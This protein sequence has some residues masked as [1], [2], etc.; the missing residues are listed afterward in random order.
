LIKESEGLRLTKKDK[1]LGE[2]KK[3][4]ERRRRTRK[5]KEQLGSPG[6][7]SG[8]FVNRENKIR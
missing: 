2:T 6:K 4:E 3:K 7:M 5:D 1:E 8:A